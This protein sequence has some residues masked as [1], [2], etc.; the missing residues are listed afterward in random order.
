MTSNQEGTELFLVCR[1][2]EGY[3]TLRPG[4]FLEA[5]E[6]LTTSLRADEFGHIIGPWVIRIY[7]FGLSD[8]LFA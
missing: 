2:S 4:P 7:L 1:Q 6:R 3:Q 5:S 8:L